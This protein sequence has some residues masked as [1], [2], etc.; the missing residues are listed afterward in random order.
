MQCCES[1]S[2]SM[3]E[4]RLCGLLLPCLQSPQSAVDKLL[5]ALPPAFP[6]GRPEAL[7]PGN[8]GVLII[9]HLDP[10]VQAVRSRAMPCCEALQQAAG[11]GGSGRVGG[12]GRWGKRAFLFPL[13]SRRRARGTPARTWQAGP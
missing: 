1:L 8:P 3:A 10:H 11:E 7:A 9:A 6:A 13:R 5:K 4:T 2:K 12:Q